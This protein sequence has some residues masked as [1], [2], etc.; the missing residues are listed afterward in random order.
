M[1]KIALTGIKPTGIPHIGNYLG[2]IKPALKLSET[3]EARYFIADYHALNACKD[4]VELK[5]MTVE[6]ASAWLAC[7]LDPQKTL[8]Y[9]QSDVPET[10]ELLTILM[11]FTP[12]GLMNRAHAYKAM[13]QNNLEANKDPDDGVNMG[14][15][16]YPVLMAA[17][18]LLFDTD[19]VPVGTDQFQ[20]IEMAQDIAQSFNYVYKTQA[21]KIPQPIAQ[22]DTKTVVGLDGR[23]MSKS[24]NNTIPMFCTEK[25]L[26]KLIMSIVTNSQTIEEPKDPDTSNIFALYKNFATPEQVENMRARYLKGGLGWGQAKQ[27]L[28][29]VINAELKPIRERYYYW[30]NHQEDIWNALKEGSQ[31]ARLLA[32]QKIAQLRKIIGI[33]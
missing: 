7:G 10:F 17:D 28:F 16:T 32:S 26:K 14:L 27:E 23:K 29:E 8:F 22:E 9:R 11:A 12:K 5:K 15:F 20:H 24:Y 3:C 13:V 18:I 33:D 30:M 1:K 19:F 6:I 31:K 4:P 25:E 21:L 2:A